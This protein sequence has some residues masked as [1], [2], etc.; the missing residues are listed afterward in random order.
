MLKET[1]KPHQMRDMPL[2]PVMIPMGI[3]DPA[4]IKLHLLFVKGASYD[5]GR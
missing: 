4:S 5:H 3:P 1:V 2:T